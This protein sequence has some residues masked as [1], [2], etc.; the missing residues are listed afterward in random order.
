MDKKDILTTEQLRGYDEKRLREVERDTRL[1]L[2]KLKMEFLSDV[3][4]KSIKRKNYLRKTI[5]RVL[6]VKTELKKGKAA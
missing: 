5:A 2:V 3:K 6:S 1:E 4:K